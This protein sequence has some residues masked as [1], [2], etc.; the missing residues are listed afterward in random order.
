MGLIEGLEDRREFLRSASLVV[1]GSIV[2]GN[3]DLEA[4]ATGAVSPAVDARRMR[5]LADWTML[6]MQTPNPVPYA[7]EIFDTRSGVSLMRAS[8]AVGPEHDPSAHGEVWTIRL[9]CKK[10]GTSSL[11]GYTLYTTCEPCPMCMACCLW[12]RLDRVVYGATVGD[13]ARFGDQILIS[14][15]EVERHS[16][17]RCE[18]TGPVE[19]EHCLKLFTNPTMQ[20]VFKKWKTDRD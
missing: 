14:S 19:R 20:A 18:V 6:T 16:S 8:N 15:R 9:A 2:A 17:I 7:A 11:Q 10:L 1:G 4:A 3:F 12:S 13:A 5:E